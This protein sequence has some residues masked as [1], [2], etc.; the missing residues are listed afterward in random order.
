[1][2]TTAENKSIDDFCFQLAMVLRRINGK[3]EENSVRDLPEIC[4]KQPTE[5]TTEVEEPA[6]EKI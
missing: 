2:T 4:D 3:S 5:T 1:M 6:A